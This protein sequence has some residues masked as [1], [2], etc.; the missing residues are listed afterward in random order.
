MEAEFATH[1]AQ[2]KEQVEEAILARYLPES[3]LRRLALENDPQV[4]ESFFMDGMIGWIGGWVCVGGG[5]L[6]VCVC[7]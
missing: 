3:M 6:R 5:W 2:V 7:V 1:K 4:H